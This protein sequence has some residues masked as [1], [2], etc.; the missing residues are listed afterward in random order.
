M[1]KLAYASCDTT[2]TRTPGWELIAAHS[3]RVLIAQGDTPYVN[4]ASNNQ[5]GYVTMPAFTATTT[6]AEALDKYRQFWAKPTA[7]ALL[8]RRGSGMLAYYQPDDHEWADDNWDH[9]NGALG[10]SF[11]TQALINTHWKRCNDA[12]AQFFAETWDN[13][14]PDAAGNTDRPSNATAESQNPPTTDYPIKYFV[15]DFDQL[16][17]VVAGPSHVR[18]IFLDCIS[19]RS[20]TAATDNASKRMLGAQQEAWLEDVLTEAATVPYV[21]ISSTKKLFRA[22]SGDDNGDTFGTYT[23]ERDRVL[24][25]IAT[26]GAKP[27][28]LSGDR[29]TPHVMESRIASGGLCDLIDVC[30]C[31]IGVP[32]NGLGQTFP[33]LSWKAHRVCFGLVT[34]DDT[35]T[36]EIRDALSGSVLWGAQFAPRSNVPIYTTTQTVRAA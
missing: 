4:G 19:Y 33:G 27:I 34:V 35:L 30:A 6:Q 3:P 15:R 11:T 20:P 16:G 28:W 32:I 26:T 14:V 31:P 8:A 5:Y 10:A 18:V 23:T 9:S 1:W 24:S 25:M 29:H 21:L 22:T 36:V 2:A 17:N 7:A 13:P 12:Q